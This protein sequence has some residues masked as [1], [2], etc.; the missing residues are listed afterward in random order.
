MAAT[1][2]VKLVERD[3]KVAVA[4]SS[5]GGLL[6]AALLSVGGASAY[7][8]GGSVIYTGRAR[9]LIFERDALPPETRGA[10]EAFAELLGQAAKAKLRSEWGLSETGA[11]GPTGNP[12][13]DP[14]GH[15]WVGV[16]RP[17]GTTSTRN[18]TT[19]DD[20]RAANMFRFSA[21]ALQLLLDELG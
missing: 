20:D 21:A 5:T 15:S 7:Y 1:I 11:T 16:V 12:Y 10:T 2:G 14:P 18:V 19:G 17:D 8:L 13:G 3:E 9:G 6:S 4:E